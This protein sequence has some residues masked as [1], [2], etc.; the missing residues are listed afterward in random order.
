MTTTDLSKGIALHRKRILDHLD[1]ID[2]QRALI[3]DLERQ[4]KKAR[5]AREVLR[6][7]LMNLETLL[8]ANQLITAKGSKSGEIRRTLQAAGVEFIDGDEDGS[9]PSVRI[10]IKT[11]EYPTTTT[12]RGPA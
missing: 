11:N 9:G 12:L 6:N 5:S 1:Q 4:D 2:R 3:A 7:M 8:A 10:N